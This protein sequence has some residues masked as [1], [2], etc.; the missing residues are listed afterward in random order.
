YRGT[1]ASFVPGPSNLVAAL[2]QTAYTDNAGAPYYYRLTAVDVHGNESPSTLLLPTGT[3]AVDG[4]A[5]A[6]LALA[7]PAPNPARGSTVLAFSLPH[8]ATARLALFDVHGRRVRTLVDGMT[9]PGEH[10]ASWDLRDD[11]GREV[12]A[13]LYLARFEAE[14]HVLTRRVMALR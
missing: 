9:P 10:V 3:L 7:P 8:E 13:G 2:S 1:S 4:A 11:A 6:T 14:G 5:P 12:G